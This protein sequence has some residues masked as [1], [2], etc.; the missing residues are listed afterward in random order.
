MTSPDGL[1]SD[2]S[3]V[4]VYQLLYGRRWAPSHVVNL[5]RHI[6][7]CV[8]VCEC[9]CVCVCEVCKV[10]ASHK[11]IDYM[12]CKHRG[13]PA[14]CMDQVD[15]CVCIYP[16]TC[17]FLIKYMWAWLHVSR[18]IRVPSINMFVFTICIY[19]CARLSVLSSLEGGSCSREQWIQRPPLDIH[20]SIKN[21]QGER[22]CVSL[23]VF[24]SISSTDD[25]PICPPVHTSAPH[26][27]LSSHYT[28]RQSE[29]MKLFVFY[30][31]QTMWLCS[32]L[33]TW[34]RQHWL[35]HLLW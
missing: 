22:V 1:A 28:C 13:P 12:K 30:G 20:P 26:K 9:V 11:C 24:L 27:H 2:Q 10:E 31:M 33:H 29:L 7:V 3:S 14:L 15:S 21:S 32:S 6:W 8:C 18:S 23:F 4:K 25:P 35:I 34:N 19:K 17:V 16:C 5:L